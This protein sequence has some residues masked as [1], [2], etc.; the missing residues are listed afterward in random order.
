MD[1]GEVLELLA[2]QRHHRVDQH[3]PLRML[4]GELQRTP[5]YLALV[6]GMVL[7]ERVD[8]AADG[9]YPGGGGGS[10]QAQHRH[11]TVTRAGAFSPQRPQRGG[12]ALDCQCATAVHN[13]DM[14]AATADDDR[15][16]G[17]GL[18]EGLLRS[19]DRY[20]YRAR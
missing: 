19:L 5:R 6:G 16:A 20:F 4:D 11:P 1:A 18:T 17:E 7:Q 3:A 15:D 12:A 13:A 2:R 8:V 10:A 9:G 14:D